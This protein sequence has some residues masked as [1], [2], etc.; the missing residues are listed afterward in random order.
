MF[1]FFKLL[2]IEKRF[3][4]IFKKFEWKPWNQAIKELY[5][6]KNY[7][8]ISNQKKITALRHLAALF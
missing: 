5:Y 7:S 8:Y 3:Y 6:I 2:V 4:I 1:L